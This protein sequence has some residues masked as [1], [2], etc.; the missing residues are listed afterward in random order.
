MKNVIDAVQV[1]RT[2]NAVQPIPTPTPPACKGESALFNCIS[3]FQPVKKS[4][5]FTCELMRWELAPHV[6]LQHLWTCSLCWENL[7]R[8][9]VE[10]SLLLRLFE[11]L[12][13]ERS[14]FWI[15]ADGWTELHLCPYVRSF[16]TFLLI[17]LWNIS[18][19]FIYSFI[20]TT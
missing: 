2:L 12:S 14:I 16:W 15:E 19:H 13:K 18:F 7:R 1:E 20:R 5:Q 6:W 4:N 11:S 17:S 10:T 9:L 8:E 3:I